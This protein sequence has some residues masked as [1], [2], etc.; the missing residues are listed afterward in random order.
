MQ[1][2]SVPIWVVL[3]ILVVGLVMLGK[4]RLDNPLFFLTMIAVFTAGFFAFGRWVGA[5][6]NSPGIVTF[7]GGK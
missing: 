2:S 7:F 1:N 6:T 5:K 3:A 4:E